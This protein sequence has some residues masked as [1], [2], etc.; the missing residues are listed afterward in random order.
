MKEPELLVYDR[1][2]ASSPNWKEEQK[3]YAQAVAYSEE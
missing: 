2:W 3:N 1:F